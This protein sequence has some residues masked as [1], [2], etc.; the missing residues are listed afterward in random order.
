MEQDTNRSKNN[1]RTWCS[2]YYSGCKT[3]GLNINYKCGSTHPEIIKK[4]VKKHKA[5]I[6][7]ALMV[8]ADRV[9]MCDEK[10]Q[11]IDGDQIIAMIAKRWREK[12]S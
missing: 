1:Q 5:D 2:S 3:N 8:D 4:F 9:I 6:G 7:I 12:N 10:S 11:I